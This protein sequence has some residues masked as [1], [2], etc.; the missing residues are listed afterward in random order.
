MASIVVD[1]NDRKFVIYG[2]K[3]IDKVVPENF[4]DATRD[5]IQNQFKN[6]HYK[7]GIID[8]VSSAG[9]ELETHFLWQHGDQNELSNEVSKG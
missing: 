3:G 2:D 7:Q 9:K 4:W 5:A 1:V 6:E 8:G